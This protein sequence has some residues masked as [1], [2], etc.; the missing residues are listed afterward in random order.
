MNIWFYIFVGYLVLQCCVL[1]GAYRKAL[2]NPSL[3]RW[4]FIIIVSPILAL[5]YLYDHLNIRN[6]LL[7]L[8]LILTKLNEEVGE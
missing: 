4:L 1:I 8:T 7:V 2:E 5:V 6:E 3:L